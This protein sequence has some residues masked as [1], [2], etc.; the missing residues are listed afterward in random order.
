MQHRK[1]L[2]QALSSLFSIFSDQV[3]QV[4]LKIKYPPQMQATTPGFTDAESHIKAL[5]VHGGSSGS[6]GEATCKSTSATCP[7]KKTV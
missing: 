6:H 2:L 7:S 1:D 3:N 4:F 5:L